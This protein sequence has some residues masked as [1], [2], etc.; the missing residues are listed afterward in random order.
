MYI[1]VLISYVFA[2][3]AEVQLKTERS[4]TSQSILAVDGGHH[5]QSI[6]LLLNSYNVLQAEP[7]FEG[8]N[9]FCF[10]SRSSTGFYLLFIDNFTLAGKFRSNQASS[11]G[12]EKDVKPDSDDSRIQTDLKEVENG[13][14]ESIP[15]SK[16]AEPELSDDQPPAK[17]LRPKHIKTFSSKDDEEF[18]TT[19]KDYGYEFDS[20]GVLRDDN[21]EAF[22][23]NVRKNH[24][25]N[26]RRYEALGKVITEEVY[27]RLEEDC[28]LEKIYVPEDAC[29]SEPRSFIF[30]TPDFYTNE[31]TLLVLIHGSGVVRA[32]Q[33]ARSII[34]NKGLK[35]GSQIPYIET[36]KKK[37]WAVIVLNT[38]LNMAERK[39]EDGTVS[40]D[41]VKHSGTAEEHGLYVWQN[42]I[43]QSKASTILV[44]AH[45][46][47]GV[48]T[49]RLAEKTEDFI[50]RVKAVAL[51]DSVHAL[52]HMDVHKL[53]E[54]F[55][56][57]N[58]INW[59]CAPTPVNSPVKSHLS[60]RGG[61]CALRSAGVMKHELTSHSAKESVFK[62]FDQMLSR[63]SS[64][65]NGEDMKQDEKRLKAE[66][67]V[68]KI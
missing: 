29:E 54:K 40:L 12:V 23:F 18:G 14:A 25:Y 68:E 31:D 3:I 26:Q 43:S 60:Q 49:A 57:N 35:E 10:N 63:D 30:A 58:V 5:Y 44:V 15:K 21:D 65:E 37:G 4:S 42:I 24:A 17:S 6:T 52:R 39:D 64:D 36:A 22:N 9:Y 66:E 50:D 53:V 48:V 67:T 45:S 13:H 27:N 11:M 19:L 38:N 47:G 33:W 34:I 56:E 20:E 46:F 28:G 16:A 61:D 51:T 1:T 59:V 32:G 62:W 41:D 7:V 55:Y 2:L 8:S